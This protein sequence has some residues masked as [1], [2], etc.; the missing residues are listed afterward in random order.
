MRNK[1]GRIWSR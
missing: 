1:R